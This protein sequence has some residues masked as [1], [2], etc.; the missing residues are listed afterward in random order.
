MVE[1]IIINKE[2][3]GIEIYFDEKPEQIILNSLKANKFRWSRYNKC[4]YAKQTEAALNFAN[5][6]KNPDT[7]KIEK[8]SKEYEE[9]KEFSIKEKLSK[10]NI[11]DIEKYVIDPEISKREN[12]N[13]MFRTKYI[14]HTKEI[15]SKLLEANNEVL[16]VLEKNND[17]TIEYNLKMALQKF[18]KNY[19]ENYKKI[20]NHKAKNPSWAVTGRSGLNINKYNK[21]LSIYDNMLKKS[22][23][24]ICDFNK[25]LNKAED[26]IRKNSKIELEKKLNATD[27]NKYKFTRKKKSYNLTATDYIFD[28]PDTEKLMTTLND[29]YFIFKNWGA[30]RVY[31]ATGKNLYSTKTTEKL[32]QAKKWLVYYIENK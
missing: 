3:N 6:L 9:E 32:D 20:I 25:A 16:K 21:A 29:E 14:D 13:S 19:Y 15:Q 8:T 27:I 26:Q 10:L 24:L 17:I 12:E 23:E 7:E 28:N 5:S 31:D 18:K 11:N 4:W 30:F 22:S 1:K 2:K